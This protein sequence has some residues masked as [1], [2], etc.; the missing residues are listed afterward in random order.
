MTVV[1]AARSFVG[2]PFHHAGRLPSV[3]LDC[4]GVVVCAARAAGF[5]IVDVLA[6]PLRANGMLRA[7]IDDKFVKVTDMQPGDVLLMSFDGEPHHLAVYAGATI[8]HAYAQARKCVEQE[9]SAWWADRTVGVY[10]FKEL[11]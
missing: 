1:D 5:E 3:G 7:I 4:I 10:R 8:I 2:T 11:A 6:Y 9:Y